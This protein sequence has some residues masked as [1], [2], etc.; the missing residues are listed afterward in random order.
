QCQIRFP[1]GAYGGGLGARVNPQNGAHYAAWVYPENSPGGSRLLKL[2]KFQTWT[3]WGYNGSSF[4]A[5][6]Q[7]TLTS[8]GTNWHTLQ[9]TCTNNQI[10]VSFD[11]TQVINATDTEATP[12]LTG[13]LSVDLWTDA[14]G[15]S[16][17]LDN[18][19]VNALT[20]DNGPMAVMRPPDVQATAPTIVSL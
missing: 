18:V 15:Y 14:T 3:T 2:V 12:Y 5:M 19:V 13:G 9:M 7:A 16:M 8:V 11:G 20:S 4:S 17:W 1:V 6:Q 10:K